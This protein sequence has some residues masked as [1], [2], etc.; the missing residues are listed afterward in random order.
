MNSHNLLPTIDAPG[1][2]MRFED[3][4]VA[5]NVFDAIERTQQRCAGKTA[6]NLAVAEWLISRE[7]RRQLR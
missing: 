7:R 5:T 2:G 3:W 1:S 4:I 6:I